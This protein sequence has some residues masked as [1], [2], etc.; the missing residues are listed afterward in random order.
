TIAGSMVVEGKVQR[1]ASCW[2]VRDGVQIYEGEVAS[3]RRFKDDVR[4]VPNGNECGIGISKFNDVKPGDE[5]EVFEVE[6]VPAT[7]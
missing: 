1:D 3:L 4:E 2:L 7:I 5:I 6:E